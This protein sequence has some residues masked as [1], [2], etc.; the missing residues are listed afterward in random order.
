[1]HKFHSL[2]SGFCISVFTET[3]QF[4][5]ISASYLNILCFNAHLS[6][7]NHAFI[8][9]II[10]PILFSTLFFLGCSNCYRNIFFYLTF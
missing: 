10:Q 1:M 9:S 4:K 6:D 2:K 7:I 5:A 3:T 8:H